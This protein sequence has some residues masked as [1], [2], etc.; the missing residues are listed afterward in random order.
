MRITRWESQDA[1]LNRGMFRWRLE[2]RWQLTL[3]CGHKKLVTGS[4][5]PKKRTRCPVCEQ[6]KES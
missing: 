2:K 6:E 1:T 3:E 4:N 5:P